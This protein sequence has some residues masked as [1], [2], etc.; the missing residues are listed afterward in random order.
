MARYKFAENHVTKAKKYILEQH[1]AGTPQHVIATELSKAGY[2]KSA[3]YQH[4]TGRCNRHHYIHS[5]P[6]TEGETA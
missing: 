2:T 3:A 4:A 6:C 1:E 5:T